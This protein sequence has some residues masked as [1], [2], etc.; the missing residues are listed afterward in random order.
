MPR[1][2]GQGPEGET[3]EHLAHKVGGP[4]LQPSKAH[5]SVFLFPPNL[6]LVQPPKKVHNVQF[7]AVFFAAWQ[8]ISCENVLHPVLCFDE[9]L[10]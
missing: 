8:V 6:N 5:F 10:Q 1:L 3:F 9:V 7:V 2:F 4:S